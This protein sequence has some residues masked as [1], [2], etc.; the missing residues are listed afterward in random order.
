MKPPGQVHISSVDGERQIAISQCLAQVP[1]LQQISSV[2]GERPGA[3]SQ[4]L[5][6]VPELHTN[7]TYCIDTH[8]VHLI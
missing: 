3:I 5:A 6:Q 2:D 8:Q 4:C 7:A 1:E